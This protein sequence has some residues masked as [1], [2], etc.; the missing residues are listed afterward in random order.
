MSIILTY[1]PMEKELFYRLVES[2]K[3][4]RKY[5]TDPIPKA[6]MERVLTAGFHA[7]SGK[8]R[9]NWLYFVL[10]GDKKNAFLEYSKK[11]WLSIEPILKKRLKPS[12]YEFTE[13]FF[14]TLGDAP[15]A[16]VLLF[17]EFE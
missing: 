7:P 8:N 3:S 9:Q 6:V 4:I 14:Y 13:R 1:S 16:C 5:K 15:Y 2:R 10:T 12:L 17:L 11:S